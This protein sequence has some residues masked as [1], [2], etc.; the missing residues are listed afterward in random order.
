MIEFLYNS[1]WRSGEAMALQWSWIDGNM[2]RLPAEVAKS[3]KA[4]SLPIIGV[5]EDVIERRKKLHRLDC[6]F[7]F[8]RA[9]K[10]IKA[11]RKTFKAAAKEIGQP[12]LLPH[13]MRRS[14]VRNFRKS[15]LAESEGMALSGHKTNSVYK[16]YDIISDDDLT[17][18]M[19]RVQEHLKKEAENRKVVPMKPE[20]RLDVVLRE[21]FN[22]SCT[23]G[24]LSRGQGKLTFLP[25]EFDWKPRNGANS[26]PGK[27]NELAERE[28]FEPPL[29]LRVNL[30]S[31]Q[32]PSTGLGH[33]SAFRVSR[34]RDL[35][36]AKKS[37]SKAAD[38]S[39]RTPPSAGN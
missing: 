35:R 4:R 19:N 27:R 32:A 1:G 8:H 39:A 21:F 13:D 10:P 31:S 15:G 7:V 3:K 25:Q 16:R 5:I 2:I 22:R 11:F 23:I 33:L 29:P 20:G 14:A 30:I 12:A 34:L 18:S 37:A 9:G 26:L 24:R 36:R 28:G 38:S 6:P 17:E